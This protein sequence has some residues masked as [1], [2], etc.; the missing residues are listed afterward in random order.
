MKLDHKEI[1]GHYVKSL[2]L[3]ASV[4]SPF[5][6][7]PLSCLCLQLRLPSGTGVYCCH[8]DLKCQDLL[9]LVLQ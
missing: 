1:N 9:I 2:V 8:D 5:S 6:L 4:P 3:I 7:T